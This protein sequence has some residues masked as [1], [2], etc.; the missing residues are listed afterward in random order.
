MTRYRI[1]VAAI[2]ASTLVLAAVSCSSN[3]GPSH[4]GTPT[5]VT[6]PP[7]TQPSTSSRSAVSPLDQSQSE[8]SNAPTASNAPHVD[9][10]DAGSVSCPTA[11]LRV[12]DAD[13]LAA[14]LKS[15]RPGAVI[16]L[17]DA[18]YVGE[19]VAT[20]SGTASAPIWLCGSSH[21]VLDGDGIH[22]GYAFHLQGAGYWRLVGFGVTNAQKGVVVDGGTHDVIQGLTV[23]NIGD[24][25]IHLRTATTYTVVRDNTI[26]DTGLRRDKFGEGVYVGSATSNWCTYTKCKPDQ[27]NYDV[28]I[29]NHISNTKAEC[30]DIKEGTEGG[31]VLDNTFDGSALTGADSWVDVKGNDWLIAGNTGVNSPEDGF[32]VH[33]VVDGWGRKNVFRQNVA[34]VNGPGYGFH[35]A[36]VQDNVVSCDNKVSGAASGLANTACT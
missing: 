15:A 31:K 33:E 19:F 12:G 7:V 23:W 18:T 20:E 9:A 22:G 28:I 4:D 14:A 1:R 13:S 34:D 27:S 16:Q 24:E 21:A 35:F 29:G 32:Q 30:V 3:T 25:A 5:R 10:A 6:A 8:P 26:S 2:T 17:D 36:P 11:T